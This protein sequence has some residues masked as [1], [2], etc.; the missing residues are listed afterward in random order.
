[1]SSRF[2]GRIKVRT[3]GV[4]LC[5]LTSNR[6]DVINL[7]IVLFVLDCV[8]FLLGETLLHHLD[9]LSLLTYSNLVALVY[10]RLD[11]GL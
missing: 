11:V 5:Y 3:L 6:L 1:M 2:S 8:L 7:Y 4:D 9:R 10:Q